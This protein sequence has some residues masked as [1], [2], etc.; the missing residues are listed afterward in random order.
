M[1][2][3]WPVNEEAI[4]A[5]FWSRQDAPVSTYPGAAA[6]VTVTAAVRL[7]INVA[8]VEIGLLVAVLRVVVGPPLVPEKLKVPVASILCFLMTRA[9]FGM[10]Q[11]KS[12]PSPLPG[13]PI[14][15]TV[16]VRLVIPT[17]LILTEPQAVP[18]SS[19]VELAA[20][21]HKVEPDDTPPAGRKI[22][23][24]AVFT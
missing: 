21:V 19:V 18:P 11:S 14:I 2:N 15:D 13:P 9:S 24:V 7:G 8:A 12:M 1:V 4:A 17:P 16:N 6:S 5:A 20:D 23:L 10:L 22:V 3:V